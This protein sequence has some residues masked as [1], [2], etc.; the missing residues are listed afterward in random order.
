MLALCMPYKRILK[1]KKV[2]YKYTVTPTKMRGFH[3]FPKMY[4]YDLDLE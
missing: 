2:I 3:K 1:L 4:I